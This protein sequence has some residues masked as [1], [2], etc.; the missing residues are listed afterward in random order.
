M[1]QR[2]VG[3]SAKATSSRN[4]AAKALSLVKSL[5][6]R[7]SNALTLTGS[8]WQTLVS[9]C[10]DRSMPQVT[11]SMSMSDTFQEAGVGIT[12]SPFTVY[13]CVL[14]MWHRADF[15]KETPSHYKKVS[16]VSYQ[17]CCLGKGHQLHS[18][19]EDISEGAW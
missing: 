13:F 7:E 17:D 5:W 3:T 4:Q 6:L 1:G 10:R 8:K 19:K 11:F 16:D 15:G 9:L 18:G 14:C 2:G 12:L